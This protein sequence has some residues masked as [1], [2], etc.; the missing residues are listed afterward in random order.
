M[1]EAARSLSHP[2]AVEEIA[3]MVRKLAG[4]EENP[5][6]ADTERGLKKQ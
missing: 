3:E 5:L 2:H 6:N 1:S 4:P